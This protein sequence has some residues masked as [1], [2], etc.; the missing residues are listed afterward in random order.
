MNDAPQ[1]SHTSTTSDIKIGSKLLSHADWIVQILVILALI[2]Y[3]I[4]VE[5][6]KGS[7]PLEDQAQYI[8]LLNGRVL[9][10]LIFL[11]VFFATN[12]Y[13]NIRNDKK[14]FEIGKLVGDDRV[15]LKQ[16][17]EEVQTLNNTS[18]RGALALLKKDEPRF[19]F[20]DMVVKTM[21]DHCD[22][23]AKRQ[24]IKTTS[25]YE[26][27]W[28]R[29]ELAKKS[30]E[31]IVGVTSIGE[32]EW[33]KPFDEYYI[34]NMRAIKDR[35]VKIKRYFI[36]SDKKSELNNYIN[37]M[38]KQKDDGVDIWYVHKKDLQGG[39]IRLD[40][41]EFGLFDDTVLCYRKGK[42]HQEGIEMTTTWNQ[43][44]IRKVNIIPKLMKLEGETVTE[45]DRNKS[46]IDIKCRID[47]G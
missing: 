17:A 31:T 16:I 33:G 47:K 27:F 29:T 11:S 32:E 24:N 25:Q 18:Y 40:Y 13:S 42:Y 46:P 10:L 15:N 14:L 26:M 36:L 21:I 4:W 9:I 2:I 3:E 12:I 41:L 19:F 38:T 7:M 44:E 5:L 1:K 39:D 43:D 30:K 34:A 45:F 23:L 22:S 28:I 35:Q 20:N 37:I 8:K 6:T